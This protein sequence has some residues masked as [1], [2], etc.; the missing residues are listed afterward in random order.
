MSSGIILIRA[1]KTRLVIH[2]FLFLIII[3][4]AFASMAQNDYGLTVIAW[5][6][7]LFALTFILDVIRKVKHL[8]WDTL[9]ERLAMISLAIL[10]GFR[11]L[12]IYFTY[13]ELILSIT[14]AGL[15]LVY[16]IHGMSKTKSYGNKNIKLRYLIIL[17]Y[18]SLVFFTLS[19]GIGVLIPSLTE[20]LGV[21]AAVLLGLFI[22]GTYYFRK[23]LLDGVEIDTP[24]YLRKVVG[25]SVILMTGYLLISVYSGLHMI[26]ALPPLYTD[27]VPHAYIELIND[28]ETGKE[29]AVDG[30]YKHEVYKQSYDSFLE[31]Y[32]E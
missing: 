8:P 10:F 29:R 3:L 7:F 12:Y 14:C 26:G 2:Y 6:C 16:A 24:Q 32:P 22:M 19:I 15:I 13:V 28:A 1:M 23:Q 30:M 25:N 20:I 4:G 27:E 18:G 21:L 9:I 5:A 17:Y 11:A 31:K